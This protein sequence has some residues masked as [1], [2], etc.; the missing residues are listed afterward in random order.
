MFGCQDFTDRLYPKNC[1]VK[2]SQDNF[3]IGYL[4]YFLFR[5]YTAAPNKPTPDA[6][7]RETHNTTLLLSPVCGETVSPVEVPELSLS[8]VWSLPVCGGW[9]SSEADAALT[10]NSVAAVPVSETIASVCLPTDR[11]SR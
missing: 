6:N 10:V 3:I 9:V 2:T 1:P 4:L 7:S 11:V 5:L 8:P